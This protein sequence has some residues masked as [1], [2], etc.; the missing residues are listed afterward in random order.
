[1]AANFSL[2]CLLFC[3][4]VFN[5]IHRS[6]AVSVVSPAS[7]CGVSGRWVTNIKFAPKGWPA[8]IGA[9]AVL[10]WIRS[11][12]LRPLLAGCYWCLPLPFWLLLLP[13]NVELNPGLTYQ[14]P[15]TICSKPVKSNQRG[16][17]CDSCDLWSHA[18]CC[19]IS[20]EDY[21]KLSS[22]N[23]PWLCPSCA[24]LFS[25]LPFA[26]ASLSSV[27]TNP[28]MP[29][30]DTSHAD[31]LTTDSMFSTS[32]LDESSAEQHPQLPPPVGSLF[33]TQPDPC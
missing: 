5:L 25:E 14:F 1:M 33:C 12:H 24:A 32:E 30:C 2:L 13:G 4:L 23:Q 31:S 16:V 6:A 10:T 18:S 27:A 21:A 15:C 26:N 29:Y 8:G 7:A 28:N 3:T 19:Y 20:R 11:S 17:C 9:L 22:D